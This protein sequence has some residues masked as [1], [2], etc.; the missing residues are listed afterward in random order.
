MVQILPNNENTYNAQLTKSPVTPSTSI[1]EPKTS[2][3]YYQDQPV[4]PTYEE[5]KVSNLKS[6]TPTI[7]KVAYTIGK[8]VLSLDVETTGLNPWDYK[9]IVCSVWDLDEPKSSMVTFASW[10]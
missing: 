2:N 9:L 7:P 4:I 8:K 5:Y 10:D 1:E 3:T 6:T